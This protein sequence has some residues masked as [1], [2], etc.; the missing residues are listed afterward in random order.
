MASAAVSECK[1]FGFSGVLEGFAWNYTGLLNFSSGFR[2]LQKVPHA[3]HQELFLFYVLYSGEEFRI[4]ESG[5]RW[6]KVVCDSTP[7][8]L[9]SAFQDCLGLRGGLVLLSVYFRA[10]GSNNWASAEKHPL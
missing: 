2:G 3:Y 7:L 9:H 1:I 8:W 10:V 6:G 4:Q 5:L